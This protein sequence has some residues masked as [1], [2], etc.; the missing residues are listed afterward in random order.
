MIAHSSAG[1]KNEKTKTC[2]FFIWN[3]S[4]I[5]KPH[6]LHPS[7]TLELGDLFINQFHSEK[8]KK[9]ALQIWVLVKVDGSSDLS[10]KQVQD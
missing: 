3:E 8:H 2:W 10:W 9:Q 7:V 6:T 5:S 1:I 4:A